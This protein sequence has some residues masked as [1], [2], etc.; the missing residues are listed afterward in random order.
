M[1]DKA[2][3]LYWKKGFHATSMRNLQTEIDMRP[4]SIYAAFGSKDGLFKEALR[5]YTDITL[6]LLEKLKVKYKSPTEVL[7]AFIKIQVVDT[8]KD[9]PNGMCMLAKTIGELTEDNQTLIDTTKTYMNEIASEFIKLIEQG[10]AMGE[11]NK[12]KNSKDLAIH[13][14]IQIAGLRTFAKISNDKSK[15]ETMID[16]IFVHYPFN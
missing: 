5:N 11:I 10:Q 15:L 8:A 3:N 7:K 2:T 14:Q 9:S 12:D 6:T 4:G 13:V 1:I 16:N